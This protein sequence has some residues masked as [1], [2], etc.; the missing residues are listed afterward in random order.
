MHNVYIFIIYVSIPSK[1]LYHY[2]TFNTGLIFMK[3]YFKMGVDK[4]K[5][6]HNW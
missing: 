2:W 3:S 5:Q 1:N 4:Y 6:W